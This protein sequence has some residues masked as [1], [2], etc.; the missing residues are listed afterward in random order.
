LGSGEVDAQGQ[1]QEAGA[2]VA[3]DLK[4]SVNQVPVSALTFVLLHA[5]STLPNDLS[6]GGTV[7]GNLSVTRSADGGARFSWDGML[8]AENATLRSKFLRPELS[9]GSFDFLVGS[10]ADSH[11]VKTARGDRQ[12]VAPLAT[13]DNIARVRSLALELGG[14]SAVHVSG[15]LSSRGY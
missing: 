2:H 5:K 7:N 9:L 15:G 6:G 8:H 12:R 14:K 13:E 1:L 3:T 4:I 11:D 10:S